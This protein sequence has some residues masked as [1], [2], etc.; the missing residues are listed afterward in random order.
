MADLSSHELLRRVQV[1]DDAAATAAFDRYVQR[2]IALVRGRISPRLGRRIDAEDV[3]QSAYRSF[4]VHAANEEYAWS[5]AGD[6]WRLLAKIALHKLFG[7]IDRHTAARRAIHRENGD[8]ELRDVTPS[9]TEP[10]PG[11]AVALAELLHL[12]HAALASEEQQVLT[13]RLRGE[14]A[15]EIAVAI[16][17]SPR[18]VRRTLADLERRLERQL[19]APRSMRAG[20]P[21]ATPD[22]RAT[23]AYRDYT[24]ERLI[25]AGGMGKVYQARRRSDEVRVALK[26]LHKARQDDPRAVGKFLEEAQMLA[27]L[28]HP[29]IV[30]LHGVGQFPTGSFFLVMEL[31]DGEN[32]QTRLDRGPLPLTEAVRA[33]RDVAQA[34]AHA[35]RQGVVHG[36]IKPAN[37]LMDAEG[38]VVVTDFGLKRTV[39]IHRDR[40][41]RRVHSAG[42]AGARR[43]ADSG[44]GCVWAGEPVGGAGRGSASGGW[45]GG[46]SCVGIPAQCTGQVLGGATV[47][48]VRRRGSGGDDAVQRGGLNGCS[49]RWP[50]RTDSRL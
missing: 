31:V 50:S 37:V 40:R 24:L 45:L 39:C 19:S 36:D 23:F 43:G 48:S 8:V 26:A 11:Q 15:E 10:S 35:H 1:G 6:L 30:R 3:V 22:P 46:R 18:T 44:R 38:K 29:G 9:G 21:A 42:S 34:I 2:L 5:R 28:D 13:A 49:A 25:G 12:F 47:G 4:F 17:K 16:R 41:H 7:Q 32:L 20:P 27:A 33:V 14:S